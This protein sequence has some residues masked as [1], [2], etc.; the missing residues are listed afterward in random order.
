[1]L[2]FSAG[3]KYNFSMPVKPN[4]RSIISSTGG[5][6]FWPVY[7]NQEQQGAQ[8]DLDSFIIIIYEPTQKQ[9]QM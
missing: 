6:S 3:V 4:W 5:S 2:R 1:M 8:E 9:S 7:Q